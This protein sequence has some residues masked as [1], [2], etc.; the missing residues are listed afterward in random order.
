MDTELLKSSFSQYLP[1]QATHSTQCVR[2]PHKNKYEPQRMQA[3]APG[4]F[5]NLERSGW[6][7]AAVIPQRLGENEGDEMNDPSQPR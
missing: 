5:V 3:V 7:L 4:M 2:W 1:A 6:H